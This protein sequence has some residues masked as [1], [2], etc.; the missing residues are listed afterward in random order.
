MIEMKVTGA[1]ELMAKFNVIKDEMYKGF[2]AALLAGS[3]PVSNAAKDKCR[4]VTG[5]CARSIHL[6]SEDG[7]ITPI[8]PESDGLSMRQMPVI[9]GAVEKVGN[10]LKTTGKAAVLCGTDVVYAP[11]IEFLIEA[12]LRPALDENRAEVDADTKRAV[13]M[14]IKKWTA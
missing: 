14:L 4:K 1:S 9:Q 3:F 12:F 2:G 7:D 5:N 6:G 8:Q 11:T 10:R 13:Q